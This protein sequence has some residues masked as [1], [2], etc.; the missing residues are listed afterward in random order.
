MLSCSSF[1]IKL[2]NS[3]Q[4]LK[5]LMEIENAASTTH[6]FYEVIFMSRVTELGSLIADQ[7]IHDP[8]FYTVLK[9]FFDEVIKIK[10]KTDE[11]IFSYSNHAL[12]NIRE[13]SL[14]IQDI[15]DYAEAAEH[16][17]GHVE[18]EDGVIAAA[19][20]KV[21]TAAGSMRRLMQNCYRE[22]EDKIMPATSK[23]VIGFIEAAI[24]S[25]KLNANGEAYE[26]RRKLFQHIF[27][28]I[29]DSLNGAA[30]QIEK[31]VEE[32]KLSQSIKLCINMN[33][34]FV[35][36]QLAVA[37]GDLIPDKKPV[38]PPAV[39]IEKI[40]A[41]GYVPKYDSTTNIVAT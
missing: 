38:E 40:E 2:S 22:I 12:D 4:A 37:R 28:K 36:S 9:H 35:K 13:M 1:D 24:N 27:S 20:E 26:K 18:N 16:D 25:A 34:A 11:I 41:I 3:Q 33:S 17:K 32:D 7:S 6:I 29:Q 31:K 19:I 10:A 21:N 14:I 30:A 39:P 23:P 5:A 8:E 15:I